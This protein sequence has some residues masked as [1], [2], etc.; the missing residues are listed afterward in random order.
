MKTFPDGISEV[1]QKYLLP[2]TINFI[3]GRRL[4]P[5]CAEIEWKNE[6]KKQSF[7]MLAG[8]CERCNKAG[9]VAYIER[10]PAWLKGGDKE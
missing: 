8:I 3:L 2:R 1:A 7:T 9:L 5:K 10:K 6:D 4:C